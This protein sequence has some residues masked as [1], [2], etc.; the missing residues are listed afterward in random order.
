MFFNRS[1]LFLN[2]AAKFFF[3]KKQQN[4]GRGNIELRTTDIQGWKKPIG[5]N[6]GNKNHG[7]NQLEKTMVFIKACKFILKKKVA[8]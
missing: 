4:K 1:D 6:Q 8:N 2:W 5:L 3:E 7:L